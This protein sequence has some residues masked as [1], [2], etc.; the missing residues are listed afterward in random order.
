MEWVK[1]EG[2]KKIGI[3]LLDE[4]SIQEAGTGV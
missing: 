2:G 3:N 1:P 4:R